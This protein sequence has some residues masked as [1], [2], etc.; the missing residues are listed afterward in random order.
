MKEPRSLLLR[1][2][3]IANWLTDP[4]WLE[5]DGSDARYVEPSWLPA[6]ELSASVLRDLTSKTGELSVFQVDTSVDPRPTI[7][8][9]GAAMYA[10]RPR[11]D[12]F[13]YCL[14]EEALLDRVRIEVD[15]EEIGATPDEEINRLHLNM[16]RLTVR[17]VS[18]LAE[19]L[20]RY[21]RR[22][23]ILRDEV[24]RAIADGMRS[25]NLEPT[26][27]HIELRKKIESA[28]I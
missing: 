2:I 20:K 10:K 21:S 11:V 24:H 17:K 8:R 7:L 23:R 6:G 15:D 18:G 19:A 5:A 12:D 22:D 25:G 16:V 4:D 9:I 1:Q 14:F 27:V 28:S 13:E 3:V 26:M